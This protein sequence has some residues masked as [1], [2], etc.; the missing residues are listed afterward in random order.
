MQL[1]K[2]LQWIGVHINLHEWTLQPH[3]DKLP[4]LINFLRLVEKGQT[5]HIKPLR[6]LG[7]PWAYCLGAFLTPFFTWMHAV[8]NAG[9]PPQKL[10]VVAQ[11]FHKV[12]QSRVATPCEFYRISPGE[13]AIDAGASHYIAAVGGWWSNTSQPDKMQVQWFAMEVTE[14]RELPMGWGV[15]EPPTQ[16]WGFRVVCQSTLTEHGCIPC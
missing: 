5:M 4:Q 11:A 15:R 12:L 3:E 13:R 8:K 10:R 2:E 14:L 16:D 7:T 1:G 6:A 9:R